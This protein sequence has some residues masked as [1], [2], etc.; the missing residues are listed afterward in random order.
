MAKV[1]LIVPDLD[2]VRQRIR[3]ITPDLLELVGEVVLGYIQ[4][5]FTDKA[6]GATGADGTAWKP[7]TDSGIR[8]R[9]K[10]RPEWAAS[11]KAWRSASETE[12]AILDEY[13]KDGKFPTVASA[14]SRKRQKQIVGGILAKDSEYQAARREMEQ[15]R[16]ER[17]AIV[18]RVDNG[19]TGV[20]TGELQSALRRG[21]ENNVFQTDE[22]SVTVGVNNEHAAYFDKAR[23]LIPSDLPDHWRSDIEAQ[24]QVRLLD[25]LN[26]LL[27]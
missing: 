11:M 7:T 16:D 2:R 14:G 18:S 15:L 27:R 9:A 5:D 23:P 3:Q 17:E 4:Q 1:V 10:R 13:R 19:K 20:D 8:S 26:D 25:E 22:D 12:Q 6:Q 21:D 24:L